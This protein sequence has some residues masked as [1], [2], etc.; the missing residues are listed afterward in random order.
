MSLLN[1]VLGLDAPAGASRNQHPS[2]LAFGVDDLD[3]V[4]DRGESKLRVLLVAQ[5]AQP[6]H[7]GGAHLA[8][9]RIEVRPR[10]GVVQHQL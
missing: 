6:D 8:P 10:R 5:A 1:Q 7:R 4:V 9:E 3:E 2:G